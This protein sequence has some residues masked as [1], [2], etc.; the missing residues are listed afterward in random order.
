MWQ[1]LHDLGVEFYPKQCN[2]RSEPSRLHVPGL[3]AAD[4]TMQWQRQ[5]QQGPVAPLEVFFVSSS[6]S[7][8]HS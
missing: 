6:F 5:G 8:T 3:H 7:L 2:I 1:L 4:A